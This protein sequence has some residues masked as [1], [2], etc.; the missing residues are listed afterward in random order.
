MQLNQRYHQV[1]G[2]IPILG[3]IHLAGDKPVKRALEELA[4]FEEEGV[5]GAIIENYHGTIWNVIETFKETPKNKTERTNPAL[6]QNPGFRFVL[7]FIS[8]LHVLN[9]LILHNIITIPHKSKP[10]P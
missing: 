6:S 1:F 8:I 3:M 4:I 5:D 10:H 9:V 2:K 7:F